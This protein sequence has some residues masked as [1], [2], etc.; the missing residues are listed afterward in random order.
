M[1][2]EDF[3][4]MFVYV[5]DRMRTMIPLNIAYLSAALRQDGFST[6]VFDTSF[7]QEHERLMEEKKKEDAGIF[8]PVDYSSIG[9]FIKKRSLIEDLL[10][11]VA[12]NK[13][14]LISFSVFSQSKSLNHQLAQAIKREYPEIPIIFGGINVNIEPEETLATDEVDMICLGEGEQA[15]VE[16]ANK[17]FSGEPIF[18]IENLGMKVNGEVRINRLRKMQNLDELP[19]PD[20]DSFEEYHQF[21]PFRGK[22]LKMALIEATRTCPYSCTYCGN[23][24]YKNHYKESGHQIKYRNKSPERLISELKYLK[25]KY[26]IE[27]INFVDGTFVAQS[28]KA[29]KEISALYARDVGL[30]FFCDA[31]VNCLTPVKAQYLK[32]M[33]CVCLNM[34]IE[35]ANEEYRK[36]YLNRTMTNDKIINAFTMAA[37]KGLETRSY[38]IIGLPFQTREDIFDTIKLNRECGVGSVSLSIFMPYEG[39][40]LRKVCIESGLLSENQF[41]IGDGTFPIIKNPYLSD[42][43]LMGIYNTFALYVTAPL[44]VHPV[45]RLAEGN[46]EF[47]VQLRKELLDLYN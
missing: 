41:V 20:W 19:F 18:D 27:F 39:T 26:G 31:T 28:E 23:I 33:G 25:D 30:P 36:K 47:A 32:D 29:L 22:L 42:E 24:V 44:P 1:K 8:K 38:N 17:M 43:E 45:V 15:I 40:V 12:E 13:P 4:I 37:D 3:M 16:L 34:G 2:K 46:S 35:T 9:V 5:N 21:G 14:R 11:H 7:Y 10:L 6:T